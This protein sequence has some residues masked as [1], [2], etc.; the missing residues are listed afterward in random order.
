MNTAPRKTNTKSR[1]WCLTINKPKGQFEELPD[2]IRYLVSGIEAAPK[3]GHIHLQMYIELSAAK[4]ESAVK[5]M[6]PGAH[7]EPRISTGIHAA[8][9]CKKGEQSSEEFRKMGTGGPNFGKNANFVEFGDCQKVD[10]P[11]GKRNDLALVAKCIVDGMSL[12]R[13]AMQ[14]PATYIR[15]YKGIANFRAL[16]NKPLDYRPNLKVHLF[17]GATRLGKTYHARINLKCWPKPVGKGNWFDGYDGHK[18]VVVDE[19]YGQWP[20]AEFLEIT[21][22]YNVVVQTKGGHVQFEPDLIVFTTNTHPRDMYLD[23]PLERREAFFARFHTVTWFYDK[24]MFMVMDDVQR[25]KFMDEAVYPAKPA[26]N[27]VVV[28]PQAAPPAPGN[29]GAGKRLLEKPKLPLAKK[30]A[31]LQKESEAKPPPYKIVKGQLVRAAPP[32][33]LDAT[34]KPVPKIVV[35]EPKVIDIEDIDLSLEEERSDDQG[36]TRSTEEY[37]MELS[38][39]EGS[40]GSESGEECGSDIE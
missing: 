34:F 16:I 24:Q 36:G 35:E 1:F 20:L 22:P 2:G 28:T 14:D 30:R 23:H 17:I 37:S 8:N 32:V 40:G 25:A 38:G 33:R 27:L 26:L 12:R 10:Q 13:A 9:Y 29:G 7:V 18:K 21:D 5:T 6:F 31:A 11:R 4:P 19:F 15:N 39:D 3:T